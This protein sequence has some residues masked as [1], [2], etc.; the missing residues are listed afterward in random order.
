MIKNISME[1]VELIE[2]LDY[3]FILFDLQNGL[4]SVFDQGVESEKNK[5]IMDAAFVAIQSII[6][7]AEKLMNN[8][9]SDKNRVDLVNMMLPNMSDDQK[10]EFFL[11]RLNRI[12]D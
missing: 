8:N 2:S 3:G 10:D 5:I 6:Q 12:K 7:Q 4:Q 9:P 1:D 11:R